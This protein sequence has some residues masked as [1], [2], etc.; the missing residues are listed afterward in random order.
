M[1]E[2]C[3]LCK[4]FA[5]K[6]PRNALQS[7]R[8]SACRRSCRVSTFSAASQIG[9]SNMT[10]RITPLNRPEER[11]GVHQRSPKRTNTLDRPPS[12]TL[13]RSLKKVCQRRIIVAL[14]ANRDQTFRGVLFCEAITHHY[15]IAQQ[16]HARTQLEQRRGPAVMGMSG[17]A[18]DSNSPPLSR[19]TRRRCG[20][21]GGICRQWFAS[22]SRNATP[23]KVN[24]KR[25]ALA[26]RRV[27]WR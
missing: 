1:T 5:G 8:L 15:S 17:A 18:S 4:S 23:L 3:Y 2:P 20:V 24:E 16:N 26:S 22:N 12:V 19:A 27:R 6:I 7:T 21:W 25:A 10:A 13:P 9:S 14:F 11:G